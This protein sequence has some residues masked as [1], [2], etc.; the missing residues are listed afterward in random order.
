MTSIGNNKWNLAYSAS[1]QG[2]YTLNL[3]TADLNGNN[4]TTTSG[5]FYVGSINCGNGVCDPDENY[6]FCSLDCGAPGC[7]SDEEVSCISGI[8]KCIKKSVTATVTATGATP[9]KE[10][11]EKGGI[12]RGIDIASVVGSLVGSLSKSLSNNL[13]W[14]IIIVIIIGVVVLL[15]WP[16][17]SK[18]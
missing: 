15:L 18:P 12:E 13:F 4:A 6:C 11:E 10:G 1:K 3:T 14:T 9:V 8:P 16:V 2:K 5:L 7:A 17:K